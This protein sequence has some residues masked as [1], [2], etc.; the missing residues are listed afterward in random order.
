MS[1]IATVTIL[2]T[3]VVGSTELRTVR[4][5]ASAHQI[6]QIHF[7]LVRQQIERHSGQE[8]KTIGD[9]FM[10]VFSSARKGVE[11]AIAVQQSLA[12]YNRTN[13]DRQIEVRIGLNTGEPIQ[14]SGDL[15]GAAVDAAARIVSEAAGGQILVSEAV[16]RVIGSAE[17][18]EFADRGLFRLKGFPEQ[19]RLYEVVWHQEKTP[20][21]LEAVKP[22]EETSPSIAVLPFVDMSA[23]KDQEY[24]CDGLA[25][26]LINALTQVERLRVVART[27]AFAFKTKSLDIQE[28]GKRLKVRTILEGSVRKAGNKLR[29]TAQLVN[30]SDGYHLWSEKYDREMQDVFA[31]QDE[32]TL[33]IVNKLKVKL[34]GDRN[35]E[36]VKRK[37]I[38]LDAYNLYLRGRYFWNK[39]TEENLKKAIDYFRMTIEKAPN[40]GLA[41]VGLADCY[42]VLPFFSSSP[43]KEVYPKALEAASKALETDSSIAEAH[44]SLAL[45]KTNYEWDWEGAEKEYL[46]ALEL[47][48]GYANGHHDYAM[49]LMYRARFEE[50]INSIKR[51][52]ELDPLSLTINRD[53]GQMFYYSRR[54]DLAI[55]A[56]KKTIEMDSRFLYAHILLAAA[57]VAKSMY[58]EA[59]AEGQKEQSLS[60]NRD[61]FVKSVIATS[62]V[63]SMGER[64]EAEKLL[65]DLMERS[66][67]E[68][69]SPSILARLLLALGEND[70]GFEWLEKGYEE[71]DQWLCYLKIEPAFD[72]IRSDPRLIALLNKIGLGE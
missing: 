37:A 71:R 55:D 57:Y 44:A 14:E 61:P 1:D 28:I 3:D 8:V 62:I 58:E 29:I 35:T 31:V 54:Y 38:D 66:K 27:S 20:T 42:A 15:F 59:S 52:L 26:E 11:C 13:P 72:H 49:H 53:M 7:Q 43:P 48:P 56:L 21:S 70:K 4:G 40:Y 25:E 30:V 5:D 65:S 33:A 51:A 17:N 46:R 64:N 50:A 68:Y 12:E 16:R 9:S 18:V 24:F 47:I 69:V 34:F 36:S 67:R 41:Y 6:L 23:Q 60:G 39:Q 10:V 19:W 2:F 22:R 45:I 63:L 32:I